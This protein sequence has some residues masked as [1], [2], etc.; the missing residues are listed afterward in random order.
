MRDIKWVIGASLLVLNSFKVFAGEIVLA[1]VVNTGN[2]VHS[3]SNQTP[4][5]VSATIQREKA[6]AYSGADNQ[7]LP[8]IIVAPEVQLLAPS[9]T[10]KPPDNRNKAKNYIKDANSA[11]Q[12]VTIIYPNKSST[13]A[14]TPR[15][16]LDKN[17]SKARRYSENGTTGVSKPGT[18]IKYGSATGVIGADGVVV[19]SC[20]D[21]NN[22][23]G[24]IGDNSQSG[25]SLSVVVNGKVLQARC[26]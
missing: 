15:E 5:N 13:G 4:S 1:P 12:P 11:S 10:G 18:F 26:Q 8:T 21:I 24:V 20:G 6:A 22:S 19:F 17:L 9:S 25:N 2:T 23:A 16:S 7:Q 3:Q 14:D